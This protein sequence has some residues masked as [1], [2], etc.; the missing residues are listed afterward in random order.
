MSDELVLIRRE[1]KVG[2]II[3]NR[4]QAMNYVD[5]EMAVKIDRALQDFAD[6]DEIR[7]IVL[8]GTGRAFSAG[9]DIKFMQKDHRVH[10]LV[11]RMDGVTRYIRSMI[12]LPKPIIASVNGM[13][14]G[15]GCNMALAA[16]LIIASA[17]AKFGQVFCRIGLIPD[18]GGCYLLPRRVGITKAKELI[19]TGRV[20]DAQEAE[21][22]GM[23]NRVVPAASLPEETKKIALEIANGPTLALG[24][25]K[26]ILNQSFETDLE[27]ILRLENSNQT[28]LRKAEDHPEGVQAFFEK[29]KPEFKGR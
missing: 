17:D 8:T 7:C 23:V 21:Q 26:R 12:D 1:E 10:E 6:E 13:A 3:L 22:I 14:V 28:L 9:G 5:Q 19:F 27:T 25:A 4:P 20:I 18:C 2:T 24:I 16:D 15:A 11:R 29:R